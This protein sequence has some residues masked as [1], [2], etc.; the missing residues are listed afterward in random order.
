MRFKKS[1]MVAAAA[2]TVVALTGGGVAYAV[3]TTSG[4]GAGGGAALTSQSLVV[5]SVTAGSSGASLYP[6]G[7]AGWVYFTVNNPNPFAVTLTGLSWGTPVST[8][9]AA[10]PSSNFSIDA[11]AP[12]TLSFPVAANS[13]TGALQITG[14]VDLS[15][16]APNGCQG[17]GFTV[18]VTVTGTQQ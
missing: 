3:W 7:P 18:P 13:Q 11:G 8:N 17:V 12:T 16:A 5:T 14:V 10:C 15:H 6:G 4:S 9:T 1:T 2:A